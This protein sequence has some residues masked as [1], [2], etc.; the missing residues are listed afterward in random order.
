[1]DNQLSVYEAEFC[2]LDIETSG[3]NPFTDRVIEIGLISF[4]IDRVLSK[5]QTLINPC[6]PISEHAFHIHGIT[7]E[8]VA[9]APLFRDML[10]TITHYI[11][12]TPLVI[13]NP[14]FDVSFL[15]MSYRRAQQYIPHVVCYDTVTLARKAFP[16]LPNYKLDTVCN[17]LDV[18]INHHRALSDAFGCME[19]F[20]QIILSQD[21]EKKWVMA[22]LNRY[23]EKV[24]TDGMIKE[25]PS[26][27]WKGHKIVK[28]KQLKI[29]YSDNAGN[30]T[31]REIIPKHIFK[32]GKQT[33][34]YAHC[35]L[36]N[37][38]RCF[39]IGRIDKIL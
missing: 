27:E 12:N 34:I 30:V 16:G 21:T 35:C 4:T 15:E 2:A 14:R 23:Q 32:K 8:M 33:I 3:V 39:K 10:D 19:I 24:E 17:S 37:E 38:E 5:F 22:D 29:Q 9:E 13:Q 1:M 6:Q 7:D 31:V 20:R 18:K 36:R 26:K 28:G 11:K 25:L